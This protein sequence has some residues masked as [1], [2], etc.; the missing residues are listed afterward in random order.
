MV[1][2]ALYLGIKK[3]PQDLHPNLPLCNWGEPEKH[4]AHRRTLTQRIT[5]RSELREMLPN[6]DA[7]VK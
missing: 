4:A 5:R 1:D 3:A 2:V 7:W 6:V